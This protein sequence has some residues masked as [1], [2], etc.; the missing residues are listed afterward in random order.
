MNH[1]NLH[2]GRTLTTRCI[3]V[4]AVFSAGCAT[5]IKTHSQAALLTSPAAQPA[6][7]LTITDRADVSL[8]SGFSMPAIRAGSCWA[9]VGD[10]PAGRCYK[11]QNA[12][13]LVDSGHLHEAYLV[14]AQHNIVGV[15]LPVE[16]A[17]ITAERPVVID[18]PAAALQR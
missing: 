17:Y 15:Y 1:T 2:V 10:V 14:V 11:A 8:A 5:D 3:A 16:H 18:T 6:D 9:S 7:H 12:V 13:L 4:L